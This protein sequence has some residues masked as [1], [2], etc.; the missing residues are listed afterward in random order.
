MGDPVN[1]TSVQYKFDIHIDLESFGQFFGRHCS[2][3]RGH[4]T[5]I[6][7]GNCE[8]VNRMNSQV[9]FLQVAEVPQFARSLCIAL[10][11]IILWYSIPYY[12]SLPPTTLQLRYTFRENFPL[13]S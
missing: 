4:T 7:V 3:V 2:I 10:S 9:S 12:C 11:S 6:Q 13:L 5:F 8:M 1:K